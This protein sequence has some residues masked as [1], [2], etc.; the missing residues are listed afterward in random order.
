M[1]FI[2]RPVPLAE[3]TEAKKLNPVANRV[4]RT[5]TDAA[6]LGQRKR[7]PASTIAVETVEAA[8]IQIGM[9]GIV[10]YLRHW[11]TA[12][13]ARMNFNSFR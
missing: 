7:P 2:G 5:S 3:D 13:W 10:G 4:L 12:V 9:R 6:S 8:R 1:V 11:V